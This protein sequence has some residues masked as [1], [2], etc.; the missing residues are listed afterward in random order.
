MVVKNRR[1]KK[2][3]GHPSESSVGSGTLAWKKEVVNDGEGHDSYLRNTQEGCKNGC[4]DTTPADH[5]LP[6][7]D[8]SS[9]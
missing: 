4:C 2:Q 3:V 5:L 7:W 1:E 6:N 9:D 8:E